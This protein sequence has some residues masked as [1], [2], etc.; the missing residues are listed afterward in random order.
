MG[1][2]FYNPNP[3]GKIVEDCVFRALSIVLE[4]DW[5]DVYV[6]LSA[7]GLA[8]SD[9]PDANSVW[10]KML[11]ENGF[12]RYAIPNFCPNC[13]TIHQFAIDHSRGVFVL[14]TGTHV[15]ALI[16]GTYFDT[17]DSGD[18]VPICYWT[19]GE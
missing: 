4:M 14:A 10:S 5:E 1:F 3:A 11:E 2:V 7:I 13:Y 19:K 8:E 9:R 16:D 15:V 12:R 6:R 17:M 18:Y